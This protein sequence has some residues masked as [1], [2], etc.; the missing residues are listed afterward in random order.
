MGR[1][2]VVVLVLWIFLQIVSINP[3]VYG[4]SHKASPEEEAELRAGE[5]IFSIV[6]CSCAALI[7]YLA[8]KRRCR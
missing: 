4:H 1:V 6:F 3:V 5:I 2:C 8:V 7:I